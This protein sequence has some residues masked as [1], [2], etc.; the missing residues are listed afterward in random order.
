[1]T[2]DMCKVLNGTGQRLLPEHLDHVDRP[3]LL[4][5]M[6]AG[7]CG[8]QV[9]SIGAD[10]NRDLGSTDVG[11][12]ASQHLAGAKALHQGVQLGDGRGKSGPR[13]LV[14]LKLDEGASR[15]GS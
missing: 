15:V 5:K 10:M 1:M 6:G 7:G 14:R 8:N 11:P 2:A 13:D 4:W 3:A 12:K 9:V